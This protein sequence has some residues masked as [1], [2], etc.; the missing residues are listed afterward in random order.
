MLHPWNT[1]G[2][3]GEFLA[4]AP[5]ITRPPRVVDPRYEPSILK[6]ICSLYW[7]Q[8]GSEDGQGVIGYKVRALAFA[9]ITRRGP[10]LATILPSLKSNKPRLQ[11][12]PTHSQLPFNV[13]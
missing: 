2:T 3:V 10:K 5:K 7:L 1:A 6:G 8:T 12:V 4:G 9:H 11:K 13:D